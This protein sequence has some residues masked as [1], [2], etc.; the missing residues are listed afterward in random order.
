MK[1]LFILL[2]LLALTAFKVTAYP[3]SEFG[4]THQAITSPTNSW[5][6]PVEVTNTKHDLTHDL[7]P[8]NTTTLTARAE[9]GICPTLELLT[10]ASYKLGYETFCNRNAPADGQLLMQHK[11]ETIVRTYMLKTHLGTEIPWI[12]KISSSAWGSERPYGLRRDKC[13]IGFKNVL[14]GE[15]AK[16]GKNYCVVDE[17]GGNGASEEFSSQGFVL[18]MGGSMDWWPGDVNHDARFETRRRK[19]KFDPNEEERSG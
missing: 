14:E 5:T 12:F 11:H 16:L 7:D 13:L 6:H 8:A 17:S 15:R 3:H 1:M 19:G 18:V 4:R 2:G 10:E 9:K